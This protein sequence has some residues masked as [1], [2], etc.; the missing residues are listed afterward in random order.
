MMVA[1]DQQRHGLYCFLTMGMLFAL[2]LLLSS[3]T[4]VSA[5]TATHLGTITGVVWFDHNRN[6]ILDADEPLMVDHPVYLQGLGEDQPGA[7]I[8]RGL[9]DE[10]GSFTFANIACGDYRLFVENG[11]SVEITLSHE[12]NSGNIKIAFNGQQIF[13]PMVGR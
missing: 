5:E 8:A 3:A 2:I 12:R 1:S 6:G 10:A 7:L 4:I 9:T 13:L 11:D